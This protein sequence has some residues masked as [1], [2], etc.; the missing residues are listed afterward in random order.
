LD[1]CLNL[2]LDASEPDTY[3]KGRLQA[4]FMRLSAGD[5]DSAVLTGCRQGRFHARPVACPPF[6]DVQRSY[7]GFTEKLPGA[8]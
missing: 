2:L 7:P 5:V 3:D 4:A 6:T 1:V 8:S